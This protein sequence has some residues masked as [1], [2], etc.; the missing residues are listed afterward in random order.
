MIKI[1]IND[2]ERALRVKT[3]PLILGILALGLFGSLLAQPAPVLTLEPEF[4][5]G[6]VNPVL[7]SEPPS[8]SVTITAWEIWVDTASA[9]MPSWPDADYEDILGPDRISIGPIPV[10]D[11]ADFGTT[12]GGD[13]AYPVGSGAYGRADDPLTSGL[14]YCYKVRYRWTMSGETFGFSDW[15][16]TYCSTQDAAPPAVVVDSLPE[17]WNTS[18]VRIQYDADDALVGTVD[19]VILY[20]RMPPS[21]TWL[22]AMA[23]VPPPPLYVGYFDFDV[24]GTGDGEYEFFVGAWD[25]LGNGTIP[26]GTLHAPMAGTKVDDTNPTSTILETGALPLYYTGWA[27]GIELFISA[28]DAY[29]GLTAVYLDT[30]FGGSPTFSFDSAFYGAVESVPRDTFVFSR[31]ENGIWNIR[32]KAIDLAG[33]HE[34]ELTWDWTF[35]V[36]TRVP[37]FDA[38]DVTDTT[39]APHRYDVPAMAGWTNSRVVKV[40]PT[41]ANDPLVDGYAS[42]LDTIAV[43]SNSLFTADYMGFIPSAFYLWT[44]PDGDGEK[45]VHAKLKDRA[46]NI[47]DS[48]FGLISLDTESPVLSACTLWN[49]ATPGTPTDTTVSLT[50]D[51]TVHQDPYYGSASGI[52]FTQSAADLNS[53]SELAWRPL[54]DSYTF[55]FTGFSS[56]EWMKLYSVLRDSAGNVSEA[57]VDSI[58]YIHG[59]KWVEIYNIS[60]IDGPDATGRYTDTTEVFIHLRYGNGI[61]TIMVWDGSSMLTPPDTVFPV[62]DPDGESDTI[63]IVGKLNRVDGWHTLAVRGKAN[64]DII[65][66]DVDSASIELDTQ[67]P[68]VPNF[69]ALDLT[70]HTEPLIPADVADTGWTNSSDVRA[71]FTGSYDTG[72]ESG[73][74][75]LYRY[76][77]SVGPTELDF[78]PFPGTYQVEFALPTGDGVYS[79]LGDVQ[80][81]AGNWASEGPDPLF[82]IKLDTRVPVIDSI[83]LLDASSLSPDYTDEPGIIVKIFGDDTPWTPAYAAIFENTA[84][85][86]NSVRAIRRPFGS[87]TIAFTLT[88]TLTGGIKTVFVALMDKAG[89]ISAMG[90]ATIIFNK[91]IVLDMRLF[92]YDSDPENQVCTNSPTIGVHLISSGTPAA[93]YILSETPG[94]AP[95]PDDPRWIP[96][97]VGGDTMFTMVADPSEGMKIIYGWLLSESFI[98]SEMDQDTIYLDMTAPQQNEGFFVWDTTSSDNFP[99]VFK[100]AMGWSNER[101]IFAQVPGSYDEGC[102]TDSM[103]F[104]GGIAL[105]LWQAIDFHADTDEHSVALS[106][107]TDSIPLIMDTSI[108]GGKQIT[109]RLRDSAG[110]WGNVFNALSQITIDGGYD[111]TPPDFFFLDVFSEE[112][113]DSVTSVL[114]AYLPIRFE[115]D[116]APGFLWKV[117]WQIDGS[118]SMIDCTTFD[119]TWWTPTSGIFYAA[120]PEDLRSQLL[121]DVHYQLGAVVIDSAGNPSEL[122]TT[123]LLIIPDSVEFAFEVVDTND[124]EDSEYCGE[125]T[126]ATH[127]MMD[128]PPDYMRFGESASGLGSWMAFS[129]FGE[130]TFGSSLNGMKFVYAQVRYGSQE[131]KIALDSIILD[132]QNPS[133]S[134]IVAFDI[135]TGDR[136]YS[137]DREIGFKAMGASDAPPGKIGSMLVAED[138]AFSVNLQRCPIDLADSTCTYT[139]SE[140]PDI[141]EGSVAGGAIRQ[142][143]RTFWVKLLDKA[144]NE[145]QLKTPSIVIDLDKDLVT[146]F[147]NPFNPNIEPT[148]VRI[149]GLATGGSVE[150]NIYDNYGNLVWNTSATAPGGSKIVDIRW[151]GKNGKGDPVAAGVYIAVVEVEGKVIKRKLAVWKGGE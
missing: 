4:T 34:N 149:K 7:W 49:H 40:I 12:Y 57:A 119:S 109:S 100:A 148:I 76:K 8:Y 45:E 91:E 135:S 82:E 19:T 142:D 16:G 67:R 41:G 1:N 99:T 131:S 62:P 147:P 137:D 88:D 94:E 13:Y 97:P 6:H 70:N 103:K 129:E 66:T 85:Y 14:R 2:K 50:V 107:R 120:F 42:G 60:D 23:I 130:F 115:D 5:A 36:D 138:A 29:S 69:H 114:P 11:A 112:E 25:A 90:S 75:G 38:T 79:I 128:N 48:R 93:A 47:S 96:Y 95:L 72:G 121:P 101:Y 31:T 134:N 145:S 78:G 143:A 92:D 132:T 80:D 146:N 127:I 84:S 139:A 54:A 144:E 136:Y 30:D 140:L 39:T 46:G 56:G 87:G 58:R 32:S 98:V 21:T 9:G 118:S 27:G 141:A 68:T 15:S 71:L 104:S 51:V 133:V 20:Y 102:G 126:V 123:D 105:S 122:K 33:N 3:M 89:N 151:D 108:E 65:L 64:Y 106:F 28:S 117:C 124:L 63:T 111:I 37:I 81:S 17:W 10:A 24:S 125:L 113:T 55:T 18:T 110:N 59:N 74:T 22:R 35:Y 44:A 150:L 26:V 83:Q 52:F 53:I 43:A 77:L 116:P 86:P 73:G 61:D